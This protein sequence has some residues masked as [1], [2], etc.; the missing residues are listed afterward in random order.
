MIAAIVLSF[1]VVFAAEFGDK[2]QL[3]TMTLATK[4][5]ALPVLVAV[6]S[7]TAVLQALSVGIGGALGSALPTN[8]IAVVAGLAFLG[9]AAWTL[10]DSDDDSDDVETTPTVTPRRL[11]VSIALMFFLAEL[12]DKTMLS[13]MTLATDR[14]LFGTWVGATTGMIAAD[15]LALLLGKYVGDRIPRKAVRYGSASVFL[16]FG[17]LMLIDALG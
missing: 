3:L 9:F 1:G 10:L 12:G 14:H 8:V 17:V 16:L 6:A 7:A 4:Y 5:R 11:I 15:G 2:S 13:S